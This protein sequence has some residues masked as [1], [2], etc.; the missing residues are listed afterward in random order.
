[1]HRS[2]R[3]K[4]LS[5]AL[6]IDLALV[7]EG[8]DRLAERVDPN[9]V[10]E[11]EGRTRL[12]AI[13]RGF[14]PMTDNAAD[15]PPREEFHHDPIEHATVSGKMSVGDLVAEYSD[16][17]IGAGALAEAVD[18]YAEM[19]VRI[20]SDLFKLHPV[21]FLLVELTR[22]DCEY[23]PPRFYKSGARRWSSPS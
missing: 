3:D 7:G 22:F 20:I 10:T 1:L 6:K 8:I 13:A 11:N 5:A 23:A 9:V 21:L 14:L 18:I 2:C 17:G 15:R 16:A 19:S 4:P 12:K